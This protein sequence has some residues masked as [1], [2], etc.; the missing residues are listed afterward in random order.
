MPIE[1]KQLSADVLT[2]LAAPAPALDYSGRGKKLVDLAPGT[3]PT[4][5]A[6]VSQLYKSPMTSV[7]PTIGGK[8]AVQ[9][10]S[11]A[12]Q[13]WLVCFGAGGAPNKPYRIECY[14]LANPAA[15]ALV[16]STGTPTFPWFNVYQL[17]FVGTTLFAAAGGPSAQVVAVNTT[18]PSAPVTISSIAMAGAGNFPFDLAIEPGNTWA[19]AACNALGLQAINVSNPAAMVLGSLVP[20]NFSSVDTTLWPYVVATNTT[21]GKLDVY[22]YTVPAAPVLVSSSVVLAQAIRRVVVD[23]TTSVAYLQTNG[24]PT[25]TPTGGGQ[26]IYILDCS[27]LPAAPALLATLP[28]SNGSGADDLPAHLFTFAGRRILMSGCGSTTPGRIQTFD[29]TA[30]AAPVPLFALDLAQNCFDAFPLGDHVYVS[31]RQGA[32]ELITVKLGALV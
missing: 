9:R 25:G 14:S 10:L 4:D 13:L 17:R 12:G 3:L 7:L 32:Q 16:S 18:V 21:T 31:N 19:I 28:F 27:A 20:G 15:P 24:N 11:P 22:D 23:P 5:A 8:P 1:P 30:P 6:A 2:T 29:V 26:V